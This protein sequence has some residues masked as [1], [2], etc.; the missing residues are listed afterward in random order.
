MLHFLLKVLKLLDTLFV[1]STCQAPHRF[2]V[3]VPE[4]GVHPSHGCG[5]GRRGSG[6][7]RQ[8][9]AGYHRP[10]Q[11]RGRDQAQPGDLG[12]TRIV[13]ILGQYYK[14]IVLINFNIKYVVKH[15]SAKL[16]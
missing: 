4:P 8:V 11:D 15:K 6:H 3:C 13:A 5:R 12:N 9:R 1:L 2:H 16:L 14:L 7:R 10:G